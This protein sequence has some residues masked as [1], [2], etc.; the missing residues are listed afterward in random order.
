MLDGSAAWRCISQCGACCRLAPEERSEALA[1]LDDAQRHL[2]LEMVGADGW[3]RHY[4]SG[5][6]RCRIY[7]N[8]PD[9]CRVSHLARLFSVAETE[10]D[11][12][13]IACCRQQ[14]RSVYGGRSLELRKFNRS[15]RTGDDQA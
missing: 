4:D 10:A 1:V 7:E 15:L 6:R 2:F 3:C 11:A 5:G 9:F 12:F 8:R 13:A 14:I